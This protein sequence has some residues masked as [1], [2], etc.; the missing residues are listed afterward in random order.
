MP[1]LA[2]ALPGAAWRHAVGGVLLL[3]ALC[4]AADVRVVAVTPGRS[5]DVVIERGPPVTI[6]V[7][8]TVEGVKLL[9]SDRNG[10]V[11]SIDGSTKTL[12]LVADPASVGDS[13][14]S[15]NVTL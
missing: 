12:P 1:K 10:A 5:A 7:G 15:G 3:P 14:G 2:M 8:E 4:L 11:V 6:E 9:R 13:S